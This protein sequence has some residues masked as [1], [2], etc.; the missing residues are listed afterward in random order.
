MGMLYVLCE[1]KI[2][3]K[4]Y[5][6]IVDEILLIYLRGKVFQVMHMLKRIYALFAYLPNTSGCCVVVG[7]TGMGQ[8]IDFCFCR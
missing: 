2:D 3:S 6:I 4:I 8:V 5:L 1:V 7:R